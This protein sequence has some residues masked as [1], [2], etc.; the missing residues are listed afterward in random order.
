MTT[1][2]LLRQRRRAVGASGSPLEAH[3]QWRQAQQRRSVIVCTPWSVTIIGL[4][5]EKAKLSK[6]LK[7]HLESISL[8]PH[9]CKSLNGRTDQNIGAAKR[10]QWSRWLKWLKKTVRRPARQ[11]CWQ[12]HHK[13]SCVTVWLVKDGSAAPLI[14]LKAKP[15]DNKDDHNKPLS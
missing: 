11:K 15:T 6:M 2:L 13:C 3:C 10:G 1:Y 12:N 8:Y 14:W 7:S 9:R 5:Y 4:D